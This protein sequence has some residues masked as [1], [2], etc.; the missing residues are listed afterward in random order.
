MSMK[1]PL[2]FHLFAVITVLI[3][4]SCTTTELTDP[5]VLT[6]EVQSAF[7]EAADEIFLET[8]TPG[9][10]ALV[11]VEGER[12]FL[13]KRGVGNLATGELIHE[14]NAFRIAS[15]TKTFTGT[16]VLMLVD[17]GLIDLNASAASYLPEYNIPAGDAITIRMLGNMTS[18]LYDY[19][20]DPDLWEA[21][22]ASGNTLVFPPDS[23]LAIAFRHPSSFAPGTAYEYCNT[24]TVLLG[25]LLEKMTGKPAA[26]VI[27]EEVIAP[28][29]LTNTY[30]AGPFYLSAPYSRGYTLGST[31]L[32]DAT[33]WDPSWGYTA[34]A[35]V[36]NLGDM[37]KWAPLLANG[38]LLS[39]TMK[40]ERFNFGTDNYGFCVESISYKNDLWIGH[41]G[42]IPG[43]NTQV[44][45]NPAKKIT[46]V[47]NSNT[48]DNSPAQ[49]LLI[50][51][52]IILGDL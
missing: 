8:A 34:G 51:Y 33:N 2:F 37:K 10:I 9:L 17:D 3:S 48:D 14:N 46:I 30:F 22:T 40:A 1:S 15:V 49:T 50:A 5:I 38:A 28:L 18:G 7:A 29:H 47:I 4:V 44:W 24:N 52:V 20:N 42:S 23:L 41:P 6:D 26:Q 45:Y 25:L 32:L 35:M 19:S 16:A 31:G 36:S 13:I 21:F 11:S 39:A 43:Y 12:N 27:K